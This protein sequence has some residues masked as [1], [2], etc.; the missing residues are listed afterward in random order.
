ME[1]W[2]VIRFSSLGTDKAPQVAAMYSAAAVL[3]LLFSFADAG[4]AETDKASSYV[5]ST[6]REC[7]LSGA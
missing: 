3:C 2:S 6:Y 5:F 7:S 4:A 1:Y